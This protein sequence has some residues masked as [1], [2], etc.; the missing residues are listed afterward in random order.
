MNLP[1]PGGCL[2]PMKILDPLKIRQSAS[3]EDTFIQ[4]QVQK[5]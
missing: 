3:P 5:N 2:K 1:I 4:G